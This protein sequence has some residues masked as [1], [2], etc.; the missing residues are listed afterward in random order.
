MNI[1][2]PTAKEIHIAYQKGE[3]A[4]VVLIESI[5]LQFIA[6]AEQLNKQ[7]EE[8]KELQ[9]RLAKDSHN[10]GKPPSSDGYGKKNTNKRT[11]SQRKKGQK[12]NGGQKGH[13][14]HTLKKSNE[15]DKIKIYHVDETCQHCNHS[16]ENEV[17]SGHEERQVFDIPAMHIE[18]TA[19]KAEIKI[20]HQCGKK[21]QASYPE[22]VKSSVQYGSGIKTLAS[23]L[24]VQ[25]FIP[26]A[27]TAQIFEDLFDHKISESIVIKACKQLSTKVQPAIDAIK[28]QLQQADVVHFDESGIRVDGKLHWIHSAS[29]PYLTHYS[30]HEKRGQIAIDEIG[31]LPELKGI[32]CHD[33]WKPYFNYDA[34]HALCNA[35]HLRE[36]SY[37][38]K[39]YKQEFA[40][41][42][43][44]FLT[45]I[46]QEKQAKIDSESYQFS[47]QEIKSYEKNYDKIV[48][49][50]K[51]DNPKKQRNPKSKKRGR[52]KQTPAYNMLRRLHD[53]KK[54]VLAFM[55][56]FHVPFTNN[57]A[58]Q[59]IRMIKV[60]QKVS[61]SF[62]TFDGAGE[63][64]QNRAYISI[65]RK[66]NKNVFQSIKTAF[67]SHPFIP[68]C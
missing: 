67:E 62:R 59:D 56:D 65:S 49:K 5:N 54:E 47:E 22:D 18:V 36:L 48:A 10:S 34:E 58:E 13:K 55:L 31:I 32:A 17:V 25:H 14:G 52:T 23:Y 40:P 37:L 8:I 35:H 1:N 19:H 46:N 38:E 26:T 24:S 28:I 11:E 66:N 53:Y 63:F 43:A 9:A 3:Q 68:Q 61:G 44:K 41:E 27:R 60:K 15:V 21:N 30:V 2:I 7:A 4:V 39:Q 50:G 33:H 57:Q 51:K 16:L 20:C 45:S 42:M 6:L 29:T 12:T 64:A